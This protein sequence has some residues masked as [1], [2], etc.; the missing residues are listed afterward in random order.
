MKNFR[1]AS[2]FW[3]FWSAEF[4]VN[5]NATEKYKNQR[6]NCYFSLKY[7]ITFSKIKGNPAKLMK[8]LF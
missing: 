3:V 8:D 4:I 2:L 5:Y 7:F 1:E 6:F